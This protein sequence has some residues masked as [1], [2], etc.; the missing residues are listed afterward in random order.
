MAQVQVPNQPQIAAEANGVP[1]VKVAEGAVAAGA[2]QFPSTSLYVG[3]LEASVTDSQLYDVFSQLGPVVSVRVFRDITTRA[4]LGYTYVNF[5]SPH[6]ATRALDMLNFTPFNGKPI[7]IMYSNVTPAH[8]EVGKL[9]YSSRIW[10][11]V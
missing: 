8:I 5:S 10:I 9:I 6:D 4:S 11:R 1:P 2:N 7:R 3:D